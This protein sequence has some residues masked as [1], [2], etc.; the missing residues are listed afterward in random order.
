MQSTA[1][2]L[3][4]DLQNTHISP[5]PNHKK[6]R[7]PYEIKNAREWDPDKKKKY[8]SSS[9]SDED[10]YCDYEND[11]PLDTSINSHVPERSANATTDDGFQYVVNKRSKS[12]AH[13]HENFSV[14]SQACPRTQGKRQRR[15]RVN[16]N[17]KK[18]N[19]AKA[20]FRKRQPHTDK[21]IL[22][23]DCHEIEPNRQKMYDLFEEMGVRLGSFIRPP[24]HVKDHELLLWGNV[25]Q[26]QKT[27]AELQRWLAPTGRAGKPLLLAR[28]E[29]GFSK[30]ASSIGNQYKNLQRKMQKEAAIQAYQQ[31]PEEGRIFGFTGSYL[32]PVDEVPPEDILGSSLEAFD[33]IR[34]QHKCHIVFD[35]KLNAFRVLTDNIESINQTLLRIEGTMKEFV[36][37][38]GRPDV[39]IL[40]ESPHPSAIREQVKV[41]PVS[42]D[43]T[44]A[45][46]NRIP[47]LTGRTLDPEAHATWLE[48]RKESTFKNNRR[49]EQSLRTCILNLPHYRGLVRMRIQF[50]TFAL[51][52]FRWPKGEGSIPFDDF[53]RNMEMSGTKGTM[54]RE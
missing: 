18:D 20:A 16:L 3:G 52:V 47:M 1:Q 44:K 22:P 26:I 27:M 32:W 9:E 5:R 49:L 15:L 35:N 11:D 53:S 14:P 8:Y 17:F 23:K 21:F 38:S 12:N 25:Q 10:D 54:I 13:L 28:K 30:E 51:R 31:V 45:T 34:F 36:A 41:M 2:K 39:L 29:K 6:E 7:I 33:P 19:L 46:D 37:K 48:K 43:D 24:Q 40:V 42:P 4:R 50:G